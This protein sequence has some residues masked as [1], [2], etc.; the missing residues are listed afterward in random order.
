[1]DTTLS[2]TEL[3][4]RAFA[5]SLKVAGAIG[6]AVFPF[7]LVVAP[8]VDLIFLFVPGYDPHAAFRAEVRENFRLVNVKLNHVINQ[9][10]RLEI[11]IKWEVRK[12]RFDTYTSR[13]LIDNEKL[14]ELATSR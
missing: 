6:S 10:D 12:D 14:V 1:M 7:L 8:L 3:G 9:I 4:L 5:L 11:V 13:I 2:S